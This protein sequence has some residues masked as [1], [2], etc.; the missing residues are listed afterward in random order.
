MQTSWMNRRPEKSLFADCHV[1]PRPTFGCYSSPGART[2][3]AGQEPGFGVQPWRH[4]RTFARISRCTCSTRIS[5]KTLRKSVSYYYTVIFSTSP[6]GRFQLRKH[7]E[8]DPNPKPRAAANAYASRMQDF[9][10]FGGALT[11][12]GAVPDAD[13]RL[14]GVDDDVRAARVGA[15]ALERAHWP[16]RRSVAGFPL[17]VRFEN[18]SGPTYIRCAGAHCSRQER[19]LLAQPEAVG[20]AVGVAGP[21]HPAIERGQHGQQLERL[22]RHKA[23]G[24]LSRPLAPHAGRL[25][26]ERRRARIPPLREPGALSR[27]GSG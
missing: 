22:L 18:L 26:R 4:G 5:S 3:S 10:K 15:V 19:R 9:P 25:P 17:T 23:C 21:A 14:Q 24:G 11:W 8:S 27:V 20:M 12:V 13:E 16:E 7:P 1:Y 6:L 2:S